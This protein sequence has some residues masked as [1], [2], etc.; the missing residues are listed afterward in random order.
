MTS[1]D[2]EEL[3]T[4][5]T[6]NPYAHVHT[7]SGFAVEDMSDDIDLIP[8]TR[9]KAAHNASLPVT[10]L[11][12]DVL[13]A[14]FELEAEEIPRVTRT[15]SDI[16]SVAYQIDITHVCRRWRRLALLTPSLWCKLRLD[17]DQDVVMATRIISQCTESLSLELRIS[18][19]G[20]FIGEG[21]VRCSL[22]RVSPELSPLLRSFLEKHLHKI[23]TL[24]IGACKH[25]L[26]I[27]F[28]D[29]YPV[30]ERLTSLVVQD[31]TCEDAR[32][33]LPWPYHVSRLVAPHLHT[34]R[35]EGIDLP[36]HIVDSATLRTVSTRGRSWDRLSTPS[37]LLS[38]L[39]GLSHV[40][41]LRYAITNLRPPVT[42]WP[43]Q[44]LELPRLRSLHIEGDVQSSILSPYQMAR[45]ILAIHMP[46][47]VHL[48][49]SQLPQGYGSQESLMQIL[50]SVPKVVSLSIEF[51]RD[52]LLALLSGLVEVGPGTQTP[53][54]P[55]LQRIDLCLTQPLNFTDSFPHYPL[56]SAVE[57][58]AMVR[59]VTGTGIALLER[60]SMAPDLPIRT[61][62]RLRQMGLS[63]GRLQ[64]NFLDIEEVSVS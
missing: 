38:E 5:L 13:Q 24:S 48:S 59:R 11:P 2:A 18:D 16:R 12:D 41:N 45:F 46:N 9:L 62:D 37:D 57:E 14:I 30:A 31:S 7:S 61:V 3:T 19:L 55:Q 43:A 35:I 56:L 1:P 8:A 42:H 21:G 27:F 10:R 32:T 51:D 54:L 20:V 22:W 6:S 52:A 25:T 64:S 47:L 28:R 4:P 26:P 49:M 58:M 40:E 29:E 39:A 36:L 44:R 34:L 50:S 23:C 15:K 17:H 33:P 53:L 60:L 63:V